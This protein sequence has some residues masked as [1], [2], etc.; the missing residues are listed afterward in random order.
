[1]VGALG[2]PILNIQGSWIV[3]ENSDV[4]ELDAEQ[5]LV[6]SNLTLKERRE[7]KLYLVTDRTDLRPVRLVLNQNIMVFGVWSRAQG[8]LII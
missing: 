8:S 5:M 1:M 2:F 4:L 7:M 3:S 6:E